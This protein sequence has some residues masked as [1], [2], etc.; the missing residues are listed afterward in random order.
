VTEILEHK[1]NIEDVESQNHE[2]S[3][4]VAN[5]YKKFIKE[6]AP[7]ELNIPS[8]IR[9]KCKKEVLA[10]NYSSNYIN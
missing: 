3:R 5:V 10:G 2:L 1:E 8:S 6:G 9:T 4:M 7:Y